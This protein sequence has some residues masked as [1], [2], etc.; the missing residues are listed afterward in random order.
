M[1]TIGWADGECGASVLAQSEDQEEFLSK[2]EETCGRGI[3]SSAPWLEILRY[4]S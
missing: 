3:L 1:V 2:E 4:R